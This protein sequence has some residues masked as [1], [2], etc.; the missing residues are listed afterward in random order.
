MCAKCNDNCET[1]VRANSCNLCLDELCEL[2][3]SFGDSCEACVDNSY[4][5]AD[6][7]CQCN[8]G[9]IFNQNLGKCTNCYFLVGFCVANCPSLYTFDSK[10]VCMPDSN[11]YLRFNFNSLQKVITDQRSPSL[12]SLFTGNS[13]NFYPHYDENDPIPGHNRGMY[14]DGNDDYLSRHYGNFESAL[15]HT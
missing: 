10:S 7:K 2:C 6:L 5:D 8:D 4:F 11:L 3:S 14:F 9:H 15:S 12:Y 13:L 1:C